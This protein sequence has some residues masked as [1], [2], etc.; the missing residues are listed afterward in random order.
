M[1]ILIKNQ[2]SNLNNDNVR[3]YLA[4]EKL[5]ITKCDEYIDVEKSIK[6]SK[7]SFN[8]LYE[9]N[10]TILFHKYDGMFETA[11][12]DLSGKIGVG[13]LAEF[14]LYTKNEVKGNLSLVED[15]N[16]N[17]EFPYPITYAKKQD[18]LISYLSEWKEQELL[19]LFIVEDFGFIIINNQL[20]GWILKNA[21]KHICT[22]Q[23]NNN[24]TDDNNIDL[25]V[26]YLYA[27]NLWE[28]N[29]ENVINLKNLLDIVKTKK[30]NISLAIKECIINIL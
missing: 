25:L 4:D 29:E 5:W 2:H 27:L 17:F 15:K 28:E 22:S 20:Q 11:I 14:L 9:S 18:Y 30:D 23:I 6:M 3:W 7:G 12:I 8:W 1:K 16:D 24:N 26:N 19:L 13:D 21:S 10:D